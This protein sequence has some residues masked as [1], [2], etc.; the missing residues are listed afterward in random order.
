MMGGPVRI[1]HGDGVEEE[2]EGVEAVTVYVDHKVLIELYV[3]KSD[4]RQTS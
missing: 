2:G 3:M 1:T 4:R